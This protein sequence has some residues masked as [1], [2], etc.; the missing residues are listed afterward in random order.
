[1][2]NC[3]DIQSICNTRGFRCVYRNTPQRVQNDQCGNATQYQEVLN[4]SSSRTIPAPNATL[5]N[6]GFNSSCQNR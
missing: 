6:I 2:S 1:M 3:R 5:S 4:I